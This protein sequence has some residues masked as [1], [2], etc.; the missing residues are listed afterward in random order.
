MIVTMKETSTT[1]DNT[2]LSSLGK[3]FTCS[4]VRTRLRPGVATA[5]T[6]TFVKIVYTVSWSSNTGRTYSRSTEKGLY[7]ME[8]KV[9]LGYNYSAVNKTIREESANEG[10]ESAGSLRSHAE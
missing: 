3:R 2:T 4:F 6:V 1:D 7:R 10:V 9:A 8:G 5:S